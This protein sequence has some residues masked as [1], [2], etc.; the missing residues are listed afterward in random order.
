MPEF[1]IRPAVYEDALA[2]ATVQYYGWQQTY[3]GIISNAYL[4]DMTIEK[5]NGRWQYNLQ[6]ARGG[7]H[8]MTTAEDKV[9]AFSAAGRNSAPE[10]NCDAEL[11]SLYL[12]KEYHGQGL[13]KR[14]F[15]FEI[16]KLKEAG[17]KSLF[18]YVLADN[19]SVAFYRS[20]NPDLERMLETPIGGQQYDELCLAWSDIHTL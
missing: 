13:G 3:R 17:Y 2:I 6:H 15:A 18:V 1:Q 8:V 19:P 11:Y 14:L 7:I 9:I 16:D 20:F 12:L 4:D 5:G 10:F